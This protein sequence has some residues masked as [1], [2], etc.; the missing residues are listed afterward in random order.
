[1]IVKEE[2]DGIDIDDIGNLENLLRIVFIHEERGNLKGFV[3]DGELSRNINEKKQPGVL[4]A[5]RCS[6]GDKCFR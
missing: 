3:D 1:M 5:N 2:L 6:P 4:Q